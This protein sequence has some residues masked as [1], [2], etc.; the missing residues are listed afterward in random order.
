MSGEWF[1]DWDGFPVYDYEPNCTYVTL[2][3]DEYGT[4]IREN[5]TFVVADGRSV[6]VINELVTGESP[7]C[8]A[9]TVWLAEPVVCAL[10]PG[11]E[12]PHLAM[13][14]VWA[15]DGWRTTSIQIRQPAKASS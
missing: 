1:Q 10:P 8:G 15:A 5:A 6:S 3:T 14:T 7:M 12:C 13:F 2:G 11:H 4:S 9:E